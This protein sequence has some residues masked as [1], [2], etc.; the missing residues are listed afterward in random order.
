MTANAQW[1]NLSGSH[2]TY[3]VTPV[4]SISMADTIYLLLIAALSALTWGLIRLCS[5]VGEE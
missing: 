5:A 3:G 2:P 1:A 4:R